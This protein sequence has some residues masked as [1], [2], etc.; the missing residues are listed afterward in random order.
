MRS[1]G[2]PKQAQ[3]ALGPDAEAVLVATYRAGGKVKQLAAEFGIL[4]VRVSAFLKLHG[5]LRP[6]GQPDEDMPSGFVQLYPGGSRVR[7]LAQHRE[8]LP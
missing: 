2:P 3:K 1:E 7:R 8:P 6:P 5:V 4:R